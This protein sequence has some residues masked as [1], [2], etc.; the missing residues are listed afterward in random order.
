MMNVNAAR[1]LS[2][3][4]LILCLNLPMRLA[5]Q[6]STRT[7][8]PKPRME[9]GLPLMQ[10]LKNR[11]TSR[12]FTTV[13]VSLQ[14]LSDMLWAADGIN[15]PE[16]KKRTAPSAMNWQE[17][18]LYVVTAD[19]VYLYEAEPHALR[20]ILGGDH[21]AAMGSQ[22]FVGVAPLNLV[23]VSDRSKTGRVSAEDQQ[24]YSAVDAGVIV[25][26]VY[27]F[28]ASEGLGCVVRGFIDRKAVGA[29]FGLSS[30]QKVLLGQT[31]GYEKK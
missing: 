11:H 1:R 14:L 22:P 10:T 26:N 31:V 5:A 13:P 3:A 27:L 30:D 24:F 15:R 6:D 19:G 25:Q 16:M 8:L 9:G 17:I 21:R 4:F 12:E 28:C 23:Y 29:L 18:S 2:A 7:V 20:K